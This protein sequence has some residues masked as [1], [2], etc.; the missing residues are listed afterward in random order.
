MRVLIINRPKEG[1]SQTDSR[2]FNRMI[3][4]M[5][6]GGIE[7]SYRNIQTKDELLKI[8]PIENP[9]LV[10][11]ANYD[12]QDKSGD[13]VSIQ[14]ILDELNVPY[15]GSSPDN[16]ELVLSKI[17]MKEKWK[18]ENVPTPG[19]FKVY[20]FGSTIMGLEAPIQAD[21]FPYILKPNR[22]GNSRGLDQSSVVYDQYSFKKKIHELLSTYKTILV[23]QFM[24]NAD[25]LHEYTVA[26]IGNGR[27]RLLMPAEIILKMRKKIRIVTTED[28][29][30]HLTQALTVQNPA[31]FKKLVNFAKKPFACA[32]MRDYSRLDLIE[33]DEKLYAIEINGLP[34]IPDKWF[35][36]CARGV[37]LDS[38]QYINAIILA[39]IARVKKDRQR[40]LRVPPQM[41]Q[42]LPT[43]IY[44]MLMG[45]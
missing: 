26:M 40:R 10:Y 43:P 8:L 39:G 13:L 32:G 31:L 42:I 29:D 45:E 25:A 34:M 3:N 35:A 1:R 22:E 16:L 7:G 27:N 33:A 30:S 18:K 37:G 20:K 28:K 9:D 11:C 2:R 6:K 24:G 38:E 23:E 21:D 5:K 4:I 19:F 17:D 44:A 14:R 41:A 12:I 36:V 15:I